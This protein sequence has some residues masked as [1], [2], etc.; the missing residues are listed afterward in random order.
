MPYSE[1]Y[2]YTFHQEP[3]YFA[4]E[5]YV[6][7]DLMGYNDAPNFNCHRQTFF[8]HVVIMVVKGVFYVKQYGKTH[9]LTAGQSILMT[10][11]DE[12]HYYT[13]SQ[14]TAHILWFH[15]RG[16][17]IAPVMQH[18]CANKKLPI[19]QSD[20]SLEQQIYECFRITQKQEPAFEYALSA[21]MYTIVLQMAQT[22]LHSLDG[23]ENNSHFYN[24][25]YRFVVDNIY[26][27]PLTLDTMC[28]EFQM[29]RTRF[30]QVFAEEFHMPPMKYVMHIKIA[31]VK[32][33]LKSTNQSIDTIAHAL[34]FA[35]H[36]HL[37][38]SFKKA[39]GFSPLQYRKMVQTTKQR[40]S[41]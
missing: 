16:K 22:A 10:L 31:E 3:H 17:P 11:M 4:E 39:V 20:A 38:R 32:K 12:H 2:R 41:Y 25:V 18:L 23:F 40:S 19:L 5:T 21:K 30:C 15:F 34:F 37:T 36:S 14:Y 7:S 9:T 29:S 28:E 33:L 13:D 8:N 26:V 27:T 24:A 6:V 35:D 1:F